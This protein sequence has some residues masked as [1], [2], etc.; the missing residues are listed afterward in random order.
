M[1]TTASVFSSPLAA[2]GEAG[3]VS[4][5][6]CAKTGRARGVQ[7]AATRA[8]SVHA[9]AGRRRKFTG[10]ISAGVSYLWANGGSDYGGRFLRGPRSTSIQDRPYPCVRDFGDFIGPLFTGIF[11]EKRGETPNDLRRR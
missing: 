4:S 7:S 3:V 2:G 1:A 9:R 5:S 11:G 8:S 10:L 6:F